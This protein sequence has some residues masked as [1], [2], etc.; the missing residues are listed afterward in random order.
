MLGKTTKFTQQ[1]W[2]K[3]GIQHVWTKETCR[4][5]NLQRASLALAQASELGI[6]KTHSTVRYGTEYNT[7]QLSTLACRGV[8]FVFCG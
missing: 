4:S 2:A 8:Y 6:A 5:R 1:V 3:F 7:V